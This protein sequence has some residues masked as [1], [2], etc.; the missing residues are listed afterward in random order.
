M[1]YLRG[2]S[3]EYDQWAQM[4]CHGWSFEKVLPYFKKAKTN[5]RGA[6]EWHGES[7]PITVKPSRLD[8][9]ICDAF[10]AAAG[11]AGYPVVDDLNADVAEG[12]AR[13]DANVAD[14]RRPA[15]RSRMRSRPAARQSRIA[16][17]D[18]RRAHRYRRRSSARGRGRQGWGT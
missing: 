9:P 4:G 3:H 1:L 10:L 16:V 13:F 15:P 12:F 7:G 6:S 8:L 5:T 18:H 17:A 14:G 2:H 11:E